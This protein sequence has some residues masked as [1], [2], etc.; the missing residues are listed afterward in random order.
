MAL[1]E[2]VRQTRSSQNVFRKVWTFDIFI[3]LVTWMGAERIL[4]IYV[5]HDRSLVEIDFEEIDED[6]EINLE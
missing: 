1:G 4:G 2:M 3:W 5:G 6:T